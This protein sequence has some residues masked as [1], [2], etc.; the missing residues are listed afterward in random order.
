MTR[1]ILD[2]PYASLSPAQKADIHLPENGPAPFPVILAIHGGAFMGGDK[3]D[4]QVTPMLTGLLRGYAVVSVNYRMSGEAKFPA[5]VQDVKAVIRWIRANAGTYRLNPAKIAAWGSSAGGYLAAMVGVSEGISV[6]ED[7]SLGNP[8]QSSR[9]QAV[10]DWFG[11]TDFLMMD[12][13]LG[14]YG[15]APDAKHA[16][17]SEFSPESLLMG[18]QITTIPQQVQAANPERYI[19]ADAPPFLIEHGTRDNLVPCL[20]SITF[21]KKLMAILGPDKVT[22]DLLEGAGHADPRFETPENLQKVFVFLD[23]WLK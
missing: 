17:N 16:H 11:P 23:S 7:L 3:A 2:L 10:V 6:L 13:Q 4:G 8:E 9:V 19:R 22:L 20:Q 14:A 1:K 18:A 12:E 21:A 5:L 15:L